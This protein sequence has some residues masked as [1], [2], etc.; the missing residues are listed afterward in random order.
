MSHQNT[1]WPACPDGPSSAAATRASGTTPPP[2]WL[3]HGLLAL[4][5]TMLFA[6]AC[7]S[8]W[9]SYHAQVGYV[10]A[11]NGNLRTEAKIWALLLDAGTAGVSLLRLYETVQCRTSTATRIS[12]LGCITA[13]VAMNLLNTPSRSPGGYLVAAVPPVMYAVFLEHL[14]A[15]IRSVLA[16][17]EARRSMW[18]TSTLW[19]NFPGRMWSKQRG[20]LRYEA[21]GAL[22]VPAAGDD[23]QRAASKMEEHAEQPEGDAMAN[24]HA[25]T[26]AT[27]AFRR[28]RGP[29]PKR[30]AF[31]AALKDQMQSGD[32]RLFS[33][34]ERERNAAAYQAAA[35]LPAP[36]SRGAARRYVVQALPRLGGSGTPDRSPVPTSTS[37]LD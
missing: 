30:V 19:I 35:S 5:G 22:A 15:N 24:P 6:L 1:A 16:P 36:L 17:D 7:A 4:A 18:R 10:L 14:L 9:L 2:N 27:H 25:K 31:E 20:S 11:H 34:D 8:A 32:L 26:P 28:G 33:E 23:S 29:G 37:K 3:A 21:E 13:S 12:L